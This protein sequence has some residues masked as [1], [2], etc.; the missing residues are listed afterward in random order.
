M[1]KPPQREIGIHA[2]FDEFDR[3]LF[4]IFVVVAHGPE[5]HPH[6]AFADDACHAIRADLLADHLFQMRCGERFGEVGDHGLDRGSLTVFLS[7]E[8]FDLAA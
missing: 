1:T 5:D 2:A 3:N 4:L 8:R 6:A 7:Q